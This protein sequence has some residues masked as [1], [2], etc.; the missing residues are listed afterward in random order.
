[1]AVGEVVARV[2]SFARWPDWVTSLAQTPTPQPTPVQPTAWDPIQTAG[3]VVAI[4]LA[5]V[6][7]IL[8][9]RI[10]RGGRGL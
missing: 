2:T 1:V 9:Y 5:L 8:G 10:F 7:A 4:V 6:A 3:A